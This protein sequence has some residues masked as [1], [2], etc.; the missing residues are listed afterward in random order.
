MIAGIGSEKPFQ[1]PKPTAMKA[2]NR[3]VVNQEQLHRIADLISG[4]DDLKPFDYVASSLPPVNHPLNADTYVI[5]NKSWSPFLAYQVWLYL[6]LI[7]EIL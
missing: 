5:L 2:D 3:V 4:L 1:Q 6:P 7:R